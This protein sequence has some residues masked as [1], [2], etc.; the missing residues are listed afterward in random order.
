MGPGRGLFARN[1]CIVPGARG[2]PPISVSGRQDHPARH[3]PTGNR[4]AGDSPAGDSVARAGA[5]KD[6]SPNVGARNRARGSDATGHE[7][8]GSRAGGR[9]RAR[10]PETVGTFMGAE[11]R[12]SGCRGPPRRCDS[13]A[14]CCRCSG[15][16]SPGPH[17]DCATVAG[18]ARSPTSQPSGGPACGRVTRANADHAGSFACRPWHPHTRDGSW[19][20]VVMAGR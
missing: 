19:L 15:L 4:A 16:G 11:R 18:A 8:A 13:V 5:G 12:G 1:A 6:D 10:A 9:N 20:V 2:D 17:F 7:D 3:W 14:G